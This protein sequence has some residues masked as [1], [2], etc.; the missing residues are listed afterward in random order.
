MHAR[1]NKH[2]PTHI[3][4]Y[5]HPRTP[6]MHIHIH[7]HTHTYTTEQR[8]EDVGYPQ[9]RGSCLSP[10]LQ[11][12]S[13]RV[14]IATTVLVVFLCVSMRVLCV[15]VCVHARAHGQLLTVS[16]RSCAYILLCVCTACAAARNQDAV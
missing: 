8:R 11:G 3:Q 16:R 7:T 9:A 1:S 12:K 6:H 10:R 4:S 5:T 13:G 2:I 15:N 14:S